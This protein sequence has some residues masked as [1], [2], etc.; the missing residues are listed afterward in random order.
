MSL[1]IP[2][3][4]VNW[5]KINNKQSFGWLWIRWRFSGITTRSSTVTFLLQIII[6]IQKMLKTKNLNNKPEL[7]NKQ[8]PKAK[9]HLNKQ[10]F[11]NLWD[12][13]QLVLIFMR[14]DTIIKNKIKQFASQNN[15]KEE[16]HTLLLCPGIMI[17]SMYT[18]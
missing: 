17:R 2:C 11:V 12:Y 10:T 5:I 4:S 16:S 7:Q 1:Q 15:C 18:K 14:N 6:K 3:P 13:A 8:Q 9:V